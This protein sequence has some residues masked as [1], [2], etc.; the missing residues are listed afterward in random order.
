MRVNS[1]FRD[2]GRGTLTIFRPQGEKGRVGGKIRR[3]RCLDDEAFVQASL[4]GI[5]SS[6]PDLPSDDCQT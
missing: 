3:W 6:M 5:V 1:G 2:G 4:R